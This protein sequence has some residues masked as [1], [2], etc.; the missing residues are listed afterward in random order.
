MKVTSG[1]SFLCVLILAVL[2]AVPAL[3]TGKPKPV[4]YSVTSTAF[5]ADVFATPTLVQGDD[6][7]AGSAVY[8]D[9]SGGAIS[10]IDSG[11]TDWNLDLRAASRGFYLT[12]VGS[13]G[14]PIPGFPSSPTLYQGR[15]VSRCFDPLGGTT[16]SSWF[17]IAENADN[18]NCAMR[19]NFAYGGT[20]YTL[21]M[22]PVYPNTGRA[23]V[24]CNGASGTSCVDWTISPN[25]NGANPG[26]ANLYAIGRNGSERFVAVCRLT[27]RDHVTYP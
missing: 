24:H 27:F 13:D 21:V 19:V 16:T 3:A 15:I 7:A 1:T 14:G 4:T 23:S 12:L 8:V 11:N 5:D 22:S 2:A 6:P 25:P 26:I 20:S 17:S 18:P 10:E 9:G